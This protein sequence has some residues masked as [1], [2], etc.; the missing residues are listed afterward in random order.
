MHFEAK[1]IYYIIE[2]SFL[3]YVKIITL[4]L[5]LKISFSSN[6]NDKFI[7]LTLNVNKIA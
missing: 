1:S 3:K 2:K 5:A 7:E 4:T 6:L